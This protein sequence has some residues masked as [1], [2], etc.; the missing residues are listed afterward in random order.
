MP[1]MAKTFAQHLLALAPTEPCEVL[2]EPAAAPSRSATPTP[3]QSPMTY[4]SVVLML[5]MG[6]ADAN[7]AS[8]G[9]T[10]KHGAHSS[11]SLGLSLVIPERIDVTGLASPTLHAEE[12]GNLTGATSACIS[13]LGSG[14]YHLSAIG[15]GR[16]G[17]FEATNGQQTHPYTLAYTENDG[18]AQPLT[19]GEA[20]TR[21]TGS[22]ADGCTNDTPNARL[23]IR[24]PNIG[25]NRSGSPMSGALTLVVAPE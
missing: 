15:S 23:A 22:G 9:V 7:A 16:N 5:A 20:L 2:N 18:Q 11:G 6:A 8:D 3:Q 19:M 1:G 10:G 21:L 12:R 24:L 4:A 13:G 14:Q 25:P 17:A